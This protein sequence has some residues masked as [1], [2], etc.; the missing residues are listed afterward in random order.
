MS[1]DKLVLSSE[2]SEVGTAREEI[3]CSYDGPEAVIA[4][5][6]RYIDEPL[7]VMDSDRRIMR[8]TETSRA[9][10]VGPDPDSDY[11]HILMPMQVD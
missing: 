7:R 9:V 6:Y 2:E 10:T 1:P 5:N 11:F 4:M 3:S 8:F